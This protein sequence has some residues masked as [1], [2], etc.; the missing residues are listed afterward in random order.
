M[1]DFRKI[2]I[3]L[4]SS[5]LFLSIYA[6]ETSNVLQVSTISEEITEIEFNLPEFNIETIEENGQIFNQIKMD[7]IMTAKT[8]FP[9][10]PIFSTS[11]AIP[12]NSTI[13]IENS[14]LSSKTY[15]ENI[16]VFPVQNYD[17][18]ERTF[19]FES[20]FYETKNTSTVYPEDIYNI[21]E[22]VTIRDMKII[23]IS[24]QPMRYSPQTKKIEITQR[25][26]I[27]IKHESSDSNPTYTINNKISRAFEP[28]YSSL[29]ANY[30]QVRLTNPVY[31]EPSL[32]IIYGGNPDATLLNQLIVWKQQR[33]FEVTAVPTSTAGSS[34]SA[35]K[36]YIQNA[37]NTMEN[38][39]EYLM[40]IGDSDG[41]FSVPTFGSFNYNFS[42]LSYNVSG[43]G[44]NPYTLVAGDDVYGD[45]F[46]GRMSVQ[47]A[48]EFQTAVQKVLTYERMPLSAGTE[49][50]E[51]TLLAGDSGHSG[52]STYIIN[53][54]IKSII[55][56]YD[57]SHT[58]H[59]VYGNGT[60]ATVLQNHTSEGVLHFNFRGYIGMSG[61]TSSNVAG[62]TNVNKLA[63]CVWLTC[64]T[65][66]FNS[67]TSIVESAFRHS[68]STGGLAGAI[69]AT[70]MA[71]S[72]TA[73]AMN[74]VLNGS[75]F[76]GLYHANFP[77]M[78]QSVMYARYYIMQV[79]ANS[80]NGP[81]TKALDS[82]HWVNLIGDPSL[83]LFKK[84]PETF[85]TELPTSIPTG[86]QS[87]S[88]LVLDQDNQPVSNAW[89]SISKMD[90]SY[91]SKAISGDNGLAYIE[92]DPEQTGTL[93]LIISK[94]GFAPKLGQVITGNG[95]II[96]VSN[97]L[98]NDFSGNN[99][100]QI[101]PGETISLTLDITNYTDNDLTNLTATLTANNEFINITNNSLD[102]GS[103]NADNTQNY[104]DVFSVEIDDNA[105]DKSYLPLEIA[106]SDGN[107]EWISYIM[108]EI[109]GIDIDANNM[110]TTD[111]NNYIDIDSP[112]QIHFNFINNGSITAEG[113]TARLISK[114]IFLTVLDS[115]SYLGNL[116]T[117]Q[118]MNNQ[119]DPFTVNAS[120]GIIPGMNLNA[121]IKISNENGFEE[122][123]PIQIIA[124]QKATTDPNGP[125]EYGYVIYDMT[126]TE[127][128]DAPTYEW[129]E[130]SEIGQNTGIN[131]TDANH[132]GGELEEGGATIELPFT[133]RY[134]GVD[135]DEI[136]ICSNG[137]FTF[138]ETEQ[139][140]FRNLPIPG[141]MVPKTIVAPYWTDLGIGSSFENG[142]VYTYYNQEDHS[143][144]IQWDKARLVS[145]YPGAYGLEYLSGV[146]VTFQ[147]IIYDPQYHGSPLGDS[148][149]KFQYKDFHP[150]LPNSSGYS[151]YPINYITV[152]LNDHT[153]N[154][155]LTYVYNNQYLNYSGA[156]EI[157]N[158]FALYLT[159]PS[160]L[161]EEPYLLV[162]DVVYHDE[163]GNNII[164]N[165]EYVNIG[166][167]I[168]NAGLLVADNT[169]ATLSFTSPYVTVSNATSDY[170]AIESME[171]QSNHNYFT[172]LIGN[173]APN[174][175]NVTGT[176]HIQNNN[177]E[178]FR[179][180]EFNI[181]KPTL[182]YRSYL[183]NDINENNNG[184][185]EAGENAKLIIN[186][187]N[188]SL[189]DV[190]NVNSIISSSAP[191]LTINEGS[192]IINKINNLSN[193]Q[194]VYD[195]TIGEDIEGISTIPFNLLVTSE[196][197]PTLNMNLA[198]GVNQ[199]GVLLQE[200]FENWLPTGWIVQY[201]SN[202]WNQSETNNAGGTSPE[203]KFTGLN[204]SEGST[205]LITKTMDATEINNALLTFKQK[206][207]FNN[208]G[209]T[210]GVA[211]R[212][213]YSTWQTVWSLELTEDIDTETV[214]V[215]INN[216]S[217]GQTGF[218]LCWF[219][220]G[221][222][223]GIAE[224]YIDDVSL[225]TAFG[226]TSIFSGK[227]NIDSYDSDIKNVRV[228]AGDYSTSAKADSSYILYLLP[229]S[230]NRIEVLHPFIEGPSFN[231]V[232]VEAG[233][234]IENQDFNMFY[235]VPPSSFN[236]NVDENYLITLSWNHNYDTES[237]PINFSYFE[238]FRQ[239]NSTQFEK[240][241]ETTNHN[242]S[243]TVNSNNRYRYYVRANYENGVSDSTT[244]IFIDPNIT[245]GTD[246]VEVPV[247]FNVNQNYPNPFNPTTNI[248][249]S[250]PEASNVN[251]K[252]YNVKGQLV[253]NLVNEFMI[254]G[255][256]TIQWNG[257]NDYNKNV[258][259]GIYFIKV[260]NN[261]NTAIKKAL[262]LK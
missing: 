146:N 253:R 197:A 50:Y 216:T 123:I 106:I 10:L 261:Q 119:N 11:I 101:N 79:Y 169:E 39:P 47:T 56:D 16:N 198:L 155:G 74:N 194:C 195:I 80:T 20:N 99:N 84:A 184:I 28:L 203:A 234:L 172:I 37:Y 92:V 258:S 200:S 237:N 54:Y 115:V 177:K 77:T 153:G 223:N 227:I 244:H 148:P 23:N 246:D 129:L 190:A 68:T 210:I 133:T 100:G 156:T 240:I 212:A 243:Q 91:I 108:P 145:D 255:N 233:E 105:P 109:K 112:S 132:P 199:S 57:P 166:I 215:P 30:E 249:F 187:A 196:N 86:T 167:K 260:Q 9:E 154:K 98:I 219:V 182:T 224:W 137:F 175:L 88:L 116:A 14:T 72:G 248:S 55:Q 48:N 262:L 90:G 73:T 204:I 136:T 191:Q 17:N 257:T 95:N 113:L 93:A 239:V 127:Y 164:E 19:D 5:V 59:E 134:Y 12:F 144:I 238:I 235:R 102:L 15:I 140:N 122:N 111:N 241:A 160:I 6:S 49:W 13:S 117:G 254:K 89:V 222:F 201:Y 125:C 3:F 1:K 188:T 87:L 130:I 247:V 35:I 256:H 21:S 85:S 176:L 159:Q 32:L 251:I 70:G 158:E 7:A 242:Y 71:T 217:L 44:D 45:I 43:A 139:R 147:A 230:Y 36:S 193:Y 29:I 192:V 24:I 41:G 205:R 62:M 143:F 180:I 186:L 97:Y 149:I 138:L 226:N 42:G 53:R 33:G 250:I 63:N 225:Q 46:V 189:L 81:L 220:E 76:Y 179:T 126:D 128:D 142:G 202:S 60:S 141:A 183:I 178:W 64:N 157:T 174:N 34:T 96:S 209:V 104:D 170:P 78:G 228:K 236:I 25:I 252:I 67:G 114:S 221:D 4:I 152:G 51:K 69:T 52:I 168:L 259:T 218:Q 165:G 82:M 173:D 135:Y 94:E 120:V 206:V 161:N 213:N 18:Q 181:Q 61:F 171:S 162:S 118:A 58:F 150:G 75:I 8:G 229:G 207:N 31:Q 208:T 66:T 185:L 131:D 245:P 40:I 26:K 151:P 231:N 214:N 22:P 27:K 83:N 124:G 163:N 107:N 121:I 232:N 103:I 110:L 211:S 2:L 65:N 38:P